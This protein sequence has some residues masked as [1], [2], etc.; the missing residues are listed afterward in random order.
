M[1]TIKTKKVQVGTDSTAS[2][3]FTIYTPGT[4]DG[5]VRIGNGDA[6][7]VTDAV[8]INSSGNVGIGTSSP[9]APL[10]IVGNNIRHYNDVTRYLSYLADGTIIAEQGIGSMTGDTA[11]YGFTTRGA[12]PLVFGTNNAERMRIDS[13]GV[14]TK[15]YQPAFMVK[16]TVGT[17]TFSGGAVIPFGSFLTQT[18]SEYSTST[19]R[20]TASVAGNYFFS[21]LIYF[22]GT[23]S[24]AFNK[25][26][27]EVGGVAP[28]L[29]AQAGGWSG[30]MSIVIYLA[31]NDYVDVRSRSSTSST[32]FGGHSTFQGFLIG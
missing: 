1:S 18:G 15:P 30:T 6:G 12:Y 17:V 3:N 14:V 11:S 13:N 27:S 2:N 9:T 10:T 29:I 4:P 32:I 24:L 5:T 8:T 31:A 16:S 7:A 20:F 21:T 28:L 25:N 19:N 26:G 22:Q 23:G